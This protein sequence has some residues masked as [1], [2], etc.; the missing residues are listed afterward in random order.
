MDRIAISL[1]GHTNLGKTTLARTLLRRDIG[2]VD[3]RPHV[4]DVADGHTLAGDANGEII[5]WDLPG[6][7]DSIKLRKRLQGTGLSAWLASTFDRWL[8]RSL[9]CGQQSLR[10]AKEQADV[11]LYLVDAL[12]DPAASPEVAA[13]LSALAW[14]EKPILLLL[15]Q[16]GLPDHSRDQALVGR[17]KQAFGDQPWVRDAM[18]LDGWTRCWVQEVAMLRR[19]ERVLP[20]AKQANFRRLLDEWSRKNHHEPFLLSMET[21]GKALAETA[22]DRVIVPRESITEKLVAAATRKSTAQ[23]EVAKDELKERVLARGREYMDQLLFIH[24]LDGVPRERMDSVV[25]GL[26]AKSPGAPPKIWG[27]L[28]G[29]GSGAL[30]GLLADVKAG[31]LTF[32]GGTVAGAILGGMA[33]YA[34]GYGFQKVRKDGQTL[35]EWTPDFLLAEWKAAAMRYL[36]VAHLGRGRGHWE[37]PLPETLPARWKSAIDRWTNEREKEVHQTLSSANAD[38]ITAMLTRMIQAVFN[39]LYPEEDPWKG[40][41]HA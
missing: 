40:S 30:G 25:E 41:G 34:L 5:L 37:E 24:G 9:W 18:A 2:V 29:I 16:T 13:E 4:T 33:F 32:G 36:C 8:D 3:D 10:N 27:L 23:S 1:A 19:V 20:E 22:R 35:M 11:I 17:W 12:A 39:E 6:F 38:A 7:G 14:T 15:N 26:K 28:G 21:L 31:G